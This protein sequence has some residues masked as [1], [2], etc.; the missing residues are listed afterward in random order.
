MIGKAALVHGAYYAGIC[1][2][3]TVARWDA[4]REQFR[5]WRTKFA[6][7]YLQYIRH[8]DDDTV[9]DV[10]IPHRQLEAAE[11]EIPLE[12]HRP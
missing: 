7:T 2:H 12:P 8:P 3:A 6:A 5:H 9:F 11:R 10:F 4:S 1:R